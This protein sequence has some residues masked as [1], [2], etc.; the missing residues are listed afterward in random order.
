VQ[1]TSHSK[2]RV[3]LVAVYAWWLILGGGYLW[4][5]AHAAAVS[6]V[7]GSGHVA[8]LHLYATHVY[9]YLHGWLPEFFGGMPFP[10]FYPPMFYWIGATL[11]KLG[12]IDATMA[13]KIITIG[14]FAILPYA[15]FTVGR[16]VG[17]SSIEAAGAS[18]GAGILACSFNIP[19][20]YTIGIIGLFEKGLYTNVLGFI[21]LCAWC[22]HLPHAQRSRRSAAFA[23]LSLTAMLLT[24]VHV[25]PLG[26]IYG[27]MWF[28]LDICRTWR[29]TSNRRNVL[30]NASKTASL[31]LAAVLI[32]GIWWLPLISWYPYALGV[33]Q[34]AEGLFAVLGIFNLVWI[35]CILLIV[36]EWRQRP[37]LVALSITLLLA[38]VISLAP[39]DKVFALPFQPWRLI[40][41][42]VF[43]A[44]IPGAR[45]CS[46]TLSQLFKPAI[47]FAVLTAIIVLAGWLAPPARFDSSALNASD[48]VDFTSIRAQMKMLPPGMIQT[49]IIDLNKDGSSSTTDYEQ[50]ASR[51]LIHQL[52]M[53]GHPVIWS[54]FR[55]HAVSAP[56]ATAVRNL[57]SATPEQFGIDGLALQ[58][59]ANDTVSGDEAVKI[60]RQYGVTYYLVKS[61][62]EKS[63]LN[64]RPDMRRLSEVGGWQ[65]FV[66]QES[67]TSSA[68]PVA[69]TPVLAWLPAHFRNR[70][71]GDFDFFNLSEHLAFT[72]QPQI[73]VLWALAPDTNPQ[74]ITSRRPRTIVV[75]DP[76]VV[77]S[78]MQASLIASLAADPSK[79]DVLLLN[80]GSKLAREV[81]AR[82]NDFAHYFPLAVNGRRLS[83]SDFGPIAQHISQWQT[84][85]DS[86]PV[87]SPRLWQMNTSYFPALKTQTGGGV[88]LTG[89]GRV[90][91]IDTVAPSLQWPLS[92]WS[93]A[94]TI[95][96]FAGFGLT[97]IRIGGKKYLTKVMRV[98]HQPKENVMPA[99]LRPLTRG[100]PP[101]SPGS[102]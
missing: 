55:E 91:A 12:G 71:P 82:R 18:A 32:S 99:L 80:D 87:G 44:I 39:V 31:V 94:S 65:L 67:R 75:I 46:R 35:P 101:S 90:A 66:D 59:A 72:G 64:R 47:S 15:L 96:F 26:A 40:S 34:S 81:D 58:R 11:M 42:A 23:I 73:P 83:A 56:L 74:N 30:I 77:T 49:E 33:P 85:D 24:N 37:A 6:G 54:V 19:A 29:V 2:R 92:E 8:A 51:A 68:E 97:F 16:R 22:S 5:F 78:R 69:T 61:V 79:L 57:F 25:L 89:Q 10:V 88:W 98:R 36:I 27:V 9:P 7:D 52:A 43:L 21:W 100:E 70:L 13:A 95:C 45:I 93:I 20:V 28:G 102:R 17:L 76:S 4:R 38:A 62:L 50:N 60:A 84:R 48:A 53:D 1:L 63:K 3:L 14:S 86:Q 41:S